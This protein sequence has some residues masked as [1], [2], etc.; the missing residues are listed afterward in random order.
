MPSSTIGTSGYG[1]LT[2]GTG[3]LG[4]LGVSAADPGGRCLELPQIE[5]HGILVRCRALHLD[6]VRLPIVATIGGPHQCS[7]R[8]TVS[9]VPARAAATRAV[10]PRP[11]A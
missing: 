4:V 7:E 2:L 8:F 3:E 11:Y 1:E 5:Q 6:H 9:P 10:H